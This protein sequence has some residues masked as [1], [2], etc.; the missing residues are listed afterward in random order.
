MKAT[1]TIPLEEWSL[2]YHACK[3]QRERDE[4]MGYSPGGVA[5][6]LEVP[7][8]TVNVWVHRGHLKLIE[9]QDPAG[10]FVGQ[11]IPDAEVIRFLESRGATYEEAFRQ[12]HGC[13]PAELKSA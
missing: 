13:R 6:R 1:E 4:L 12:V 8:Q 5:A 10:G 9:L 3:T 2:R 7:R 11:Y